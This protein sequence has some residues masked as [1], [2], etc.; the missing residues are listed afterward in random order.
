MATLDQIVDGIADRL[1]TIAGLNVVRYFPG[2]ITPPVAV[3]GIPTITEYHSSMGRALMALEAPVHVFTGSQVDVEGQRKLAGFANPTGA[4]S[5]KAAIEAD[6]K[7]NNRVEDCIVREF[8]PL[9]LE[10]YSALNYFGGVF[11]LQIYARG[12]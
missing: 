3:V 4:L 7:L 12:S 5:F 1:G 6:R 10:E 8:R 2:A 9:N 11:T